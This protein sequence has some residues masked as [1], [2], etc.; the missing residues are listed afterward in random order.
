MVQAFSM[1]SVEGD[2]YNPFS[3]NYESSNY[4]QYRNAT[5]STQKALASNIASTHR[6][7]LSKAMACLQDGDVSAFD[8]IIDGILSEEQSKSRTYNITAS[9]IQSAIEDAFRIVTENSYDNAVANATSGSFSCGW[10]QA[11]L[12]NL[13]GAAPDTTESTA[14]VNSKRHGTKLKES[15]IQKEVWGGALHGALDYGLMGGALCAGL[16]TL[17]VLNSW[18]P[19]GWI[20]IGAAILGGVI[21]GRKVCKNNKASGTAQ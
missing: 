8:S 9:E 4:R 11:G 2:C 21:G 1:S 3:S 13:L 20:C 18:N 16:A 5:A 10:E 6:T 7:E 14:E 15:E 19:V 12:L 17:G